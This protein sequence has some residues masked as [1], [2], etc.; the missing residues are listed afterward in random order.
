V[1][2]PGENSNARDE[3]SRHHEGIDKLVN[4]SKTTAPMIEKQTVD[5]LKKKLKIPTGYQCIKEEV[6][7]MLKATSLPNPTAK[8]GKT[9]STKVGE[10]EVK[11]IPV[12]L[13]NRKIK[14]LKEV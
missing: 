3:K 10:Q 9:I 13:H 1:H 6:A 5:L 8:K 11:N 4:E 14:M 12:T 2:V 7:H